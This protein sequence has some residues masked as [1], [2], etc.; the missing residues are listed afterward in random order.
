MH[1]PQISSSHLTP[2]VHLLFH[3]AHT[4]C[5]HGATTALHFSW[6][7]ALCIHAALQPFITGE[8]MRWV[9]FVTCD[10]RST[11]PIAGNSY[12]PKLNLSILLFL[13]CTLTWQ[14]S[15]LSSANFTSNFHINDSEDMDL[16]EV[17][18]L[19]FLMVMKLAILGGYIMQ[20]KYVAK[21]QVTLVYFG[22]FL[23]KWL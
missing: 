5:R 15:A 16:E 6:L 10:G 9:P 18:T 11:N 3:M 19:K 12:M 23:R 22:C 21:E 14:S 13:S 7:Q 1:P 8:V 2:P 20:H 17:R 4:T